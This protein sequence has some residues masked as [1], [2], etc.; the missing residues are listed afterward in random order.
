MPS[1]HA[2]AACAA[3]RPARGHRPTTDPSR[4]TAK[5]MN[6]P[7]ET[8]T[9]TVDQ[10]CRRQDP[11]WMPWHSG[12]GEWY[13]IGRSFS[14]CRRAALARS[15]GRGGTGFQLRRIWYRGAR[16]RAAGKLHSVGGR[17]AATLVCT[18]C[19]AFVNAVPAFFSGQLDRRM[20]RRACRCCRR[21]CGAVVG[22]Y[23]DT[24][25]ANDGSG[26]IRM[27]YLARRCSGVDCDTNLCATLSAATSTPAL[28]RSTIER[29]TE[30]HAGNGIRLPARQLVESTTK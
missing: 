27:G 6:T 10:M 2:H 20:S 26:P 11:G 1:V 15:G 24:S 17:L 9:K 30:Y 22:V 16:A 25:P 5:R 8:A 29:S 4:E 14:V 3:A 7:T 28:S 19:A 12:H 18:Q 13:F 21:Q 23:S